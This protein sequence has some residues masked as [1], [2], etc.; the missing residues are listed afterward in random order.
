MTVTARC[1][2]LTCDPDDPFTLP[3]IGPGDGEVSGLLV[4][5]EADIARLEFV[6]TALGATG[7]RRILLERNG[8]V[9]EVKTCCGHP[10]SGAWHLTEWQAR[11]GEVM[12]VAMQEIIGQVDQCPAEDLAMRLPMVLS[13][14]A[15]RVAARAGTPALL[16]SDTPSE[17]VRTLACDTLHAGF[18]LTRGYSL[19]HP[20]FDGTM[21]PEMQREVFVATDAAL[22]LPYDPLRDRVMLVEQFRMGPFGRGDPRPWMLEPVAGRIDPGETPEETARRECLEEAGLPLRALEK[23]STHYCTPGYSTEVFHLFL[24]LCELPDMKQGQG[25]LDSEHEDIRT[26]VIGFD[27]AMALLESGEANNGPLVLSLIWLQR[28]RARL[29][30]SA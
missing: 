19:R 8:A 13:R 18:F 25:G 27:R 28:E 14:A 6:A 20:R 24:G 22:V 21:S 15:A 5:D 11:G 1:H 10:G 30:A 29:R 17:A 26:H 3:E 4:C 7:W 12:R 23:I 2:V 9:L 16:R